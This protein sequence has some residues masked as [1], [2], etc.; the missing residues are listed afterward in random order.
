M[1]LCR[2]DETNRKLACPM[3]DRRNP[4]TGC[5]H[6]LTCNQSSRPGD[7]H[8]DLGHTFCLKLVKTSHQPPGPVIRTLLVNLPPRGCSWSSSCFSLYPRMPSH[9]A[10]DC[11]CF[12]DESKVVVN[13]VGRGSFSFHCSEWSSPR[14]SDQQDDDKAGA[15]APMI[16]AESLLRTR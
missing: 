15:D 14:F 5:G 4:Q 1:L 16:R 13:C 8:I 6:G 12:S 2:I 10:F 7:E 11:C 3:D 9:L